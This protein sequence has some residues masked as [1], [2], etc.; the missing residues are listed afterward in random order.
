MKNFS[1]KEIHEASTKY[2]GIGLTISVEF[3]RW[4]MILRG[5][6]DRTLATCEIDHY[7]REYSYA[8]LD[9]LSDEVDINWLVDEFKH[10]YSTHLRTAEIKAQFS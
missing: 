8:M 2:L 5:C 4:G 7:N 9:N 1:L 3:T 10:E 6:W